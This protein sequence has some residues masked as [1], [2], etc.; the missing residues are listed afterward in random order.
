MLF[1]TL[2]VLILVAG[3]AAFFFLRHEPDIACI[4]LVF[5]LFVPIPIAAGID[6]RINTR[7]FQEQKAYI[8]TYTPEDPLE[9]AALTTKRVELNEWLFNAQ[10]RR[11]AFG[12]ASLY[13]AEVL[14]LEPIK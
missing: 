7:V 4:C 6:Q 3:L 14:E 2:A 13:P 9:N 12:F 10:T 1:W 11:S 8:E 5:L